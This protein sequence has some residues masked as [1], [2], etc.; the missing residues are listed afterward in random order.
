M[1]ASTIA[2]KNHQPSDHFLLFS[3]GY[4][5]EVGLTPTEDQRRGGGGGRRVT[6]DAG[7]SLGS[8]SHRP[9]PLAARIRGHIDTRHRIMSRHIPQNIIIEP[10]TFTV[11]L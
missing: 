2:L 8:A 4:G 11:W 6:A 10:I 3:V 7:L 1:P 9:R 5:C